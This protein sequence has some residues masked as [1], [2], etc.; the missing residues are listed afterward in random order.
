MLSCR[1][2]P[3]LAGCQS[4]TKP[5]KWIYTATQSREAVCREQEEQVPLVL[6]GIYSQVQTQT[7]A[8]WTAHEWGSNHANGETEGPPFQGCPG[9]GWLWM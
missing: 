3:G 5:R 2:G 9:A 1:S 6:M 7:K 8:L 4:T